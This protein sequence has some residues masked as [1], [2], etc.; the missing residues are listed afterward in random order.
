VRCAFGAVLVCLVC[1]DLRSCGF[2]RGLGSPLLL[3]LLLLLLLPWRREI[4]VSRLAL[5]LETRWKSGGAGRLQ[6]CRFGKSRLPKRLQK[7]HSLL[8]VAKAPVPL[9]ST[10]KIRSN[11]DQKPIDHKIQRD[12]TPTT[13]LSDHPTKCRYQQ[14][15]RTQLDPHRR[16]VGCLPP[17]CGALRR[18]NSSLAANGLCNLVGEVDFYFGPL[19]VVPALAYVPDA[20]AFDRSN[21]LEYFSDVAWSVVGASCCMVLC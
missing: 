11:L 2:G 4:L 15:S 3:L 18:I 13:P 17:A 19:L 5:P 10:S 20:F 7:Q 12:S 21:V 6:L 9:S 14:A 16:A 8:S 1:S